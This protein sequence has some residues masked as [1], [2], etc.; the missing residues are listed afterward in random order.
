MQRD[1]QFPVQFPGYV[2]NK[3]KYIKYNWGQ[4]RRPMYTFLGSGC[5][6]LYRTKNVQLWIG[7]IKVII[8][9][10]DK[11]MLRNV[12]FKDVY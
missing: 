1:V 4:C 11:P 6:F 9:I 2:I 10:F 8:M 12:L 7:L 3:L 5:S